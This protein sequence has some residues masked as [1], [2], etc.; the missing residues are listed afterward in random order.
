LDFDCEVVEDNRFSNDISIE[1]ITDLCDLTLIPPKSTPCDEAAKTKHERVK[2]NKKR[3]PCFVCRYRLDMQGGR[4]PILCPVNAP[5]VEL[6]RNSSTPSRR[7][8]TFQ[9][10]VSICETIHEDSPALR[11]ARRKSTAIRDNITPSKWKISPKRSNSDRRKSVSKNV[12]SPIKLINVVSPI[13]LINVK[14]ER[15]TPEDVLS[16]MNDDDSDTENGSPNKKSKRLTQAKTK[17]V[18]KNLN[19]SI[20]SHDGTADSDT[21][22]YSIVRDAAVQDN[23][24]KLRLSETQK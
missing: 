8:S 9:R 19:A 4:N 14:V 10:R 24:I 18:K 13:K 1:S 16:I 22:N 20:S 23:K 15:L 2:L 6:Q 7:P 3:M 21:L 12:V 5:T 11:V 17:N